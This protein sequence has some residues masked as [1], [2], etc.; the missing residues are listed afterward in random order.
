MP[1]LPSCAA[2]DPYLRVVPLFETLDDLK[3]AETAVRQLFSNEWYRKHIDG[4]Q[5]IMIGYSDSGKDAGRLAAAWGIYEVQEKL[6]KV[7]ALGLGLG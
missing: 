2:V 3:Y 5:E 1:P 7:R 6:T 4:H